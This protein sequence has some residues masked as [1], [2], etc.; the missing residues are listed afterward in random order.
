MKGQNLV[1]DIDAK[2]DSLEIVKRISTSH[3]INWAYDIA[4]AMEF[5][6]SKNV[7]DDSILNYICLL[8]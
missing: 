2:N 6:S 1:I 8:P 7:R 4:S 3:L 5:L